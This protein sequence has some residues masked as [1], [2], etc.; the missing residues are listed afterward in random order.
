[1]NRFVR[2]PHSPD[3]TCQSC[4][5]TSDDRYIKVRPPQVVRRDP[6]IPG[7]DLPI[8]GQCYRTWVEEH[9]V[10]LPLGIEPEETDLGPL[11]IK[12]LK[13]IG[14][15]QDEIEAQ[16]HKIPKLTLKAIPVPSLK[17]MLSGDL[18]KVPGFGLC[19]L[20]ERGKT[21]AIAAI[22]AG[23]LRQWAE[24]LAPFRRLPFQGPTEQMTSI[25]WM[26]IPTMIGAW[27]RN[28]INPKIDEF[29]RRAQATKLLI[30]DDF[31]RERPGKEGDAA[32]S[33]L[34][35]ILTARDRAGLPTLWTS[36]FDQAELE[37][38]YDAP[39]SRRLFRLNPPK[40]IEE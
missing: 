18:A 39:V 17:T 29:V 26:N 24:N 16:L 9:G 15:G 27:R 11:V 31:G 20:A 21:Q 23:G 38:R 19:G 37:D 8:C 28:G 5:V 3:L 32:T 34:D 1:M 2:S 14:L 33:H 35:A 40:W 4:G 7:H 36:N 25:T 22:L 30:A 13:D 10:Y 12:W 6:P